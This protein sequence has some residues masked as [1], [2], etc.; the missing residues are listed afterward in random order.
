[1][2]GKTRIKD[3]GQVLGPDQL[4]MALG[5]DRPCL[6]VMPAQQLASHRAWDVEEVDLIDQDANLLE[7]RGTGERA[8]LVVAGRHDAG[9]VR[10]RLL[11]TAARLVELARSRDLGSGHQDVQ[12]GLGQ[13]GT[14]DGDLADLM[15][16]FADPV[17]QSD[18]GRPRASTKGGFWHNLAHA[19]FG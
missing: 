4:A 6:H 1:M 17:P 5:R 14:L 12:L 9:E 7:Q 3:D 16:F 18:P 11:D 19:A 15:R 13:I 2:T 8:Y 10:R